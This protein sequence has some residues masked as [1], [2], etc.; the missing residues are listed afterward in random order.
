VPILYGAFNPADQF[1]PG[2]DVVWPAPGV[3]D[4]Q[5]GMPRVRV[6]VN[7]L[8][9][10]TSTNGQ[11]IVRTDKYPDMQG[12]L[13]FGDPVG[14]LVRRA[15]IVKTEGLTQLRNVYPGSEFIVSEDP[16]FRPLNIK[17]G[18]D[19][20]LY[21]VDM[22][23]GIIQDAN[24]TGRG[25]YLRTR[26]EQYS[27]DKAT[28]HG[29]VWRLRFDGIPAIPS[30]PPIAA[31]AAVPGIELDR[32]VPRML[33]ET[34]AQLVSHL[35]SS[36]GWW[37]DTAQRLL[38]LKQDKS[39]V[40][41][42]QQMVR[43]PGSGNASGNPGSLVARFHAMW[44][45]EGLGALDA[46]L[47]RDA[48]K[49]PSPRMRVQAI[50]A[51]ETLYKA[52]NRTF[53]ADYRAMAKDSDADVAIQALMTLNLFK[54]PDIADVVKTAQ[55]AN[56]GRGVK[57]LGDL[58]V[59]PA[60]AGRGGGRGGPVLTAEQ[61]QLMEKG[62]AIYGELCFSCHGD[63]G[64]GR[65]LAGVVGAMMAP[66]LAGSPRVN[67]HR[68]YVV[69]T[70]LKGLTGPLGEATYSEVMVPMGTNTDE[71]IA[72]ISSY[73]RGSFGNPGG[74]VS[75]PDVARVRAATASRKT[76]WTESTLEATLPHQLDV[77]PEWKVTASH[78]SSAA[79]AALSMRTWT[80]GAPQ[81]P[82]MW[83]QV[84][85][86]QP[87]ML[88]EIQFDAPPAGRGGGAGRGGAAGAPAAPVIPYP[89]G[90]RVE[91]SLD[92]SKWGKPVAEGKG[93]GT[94]T[95]VAF[96]PVRAKFVRITQTD[97]VDN[98]PNWT[99]TNVRLFEAGSAK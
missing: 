58:L 47:V 37:R 65:P 49:D 12:D 20:A 10:F 53:D 73:V 3:G 63:D 66:A 22:Y 21:I 98:G 36:N 16:L 88:T 17:L 55:G 2:F 33:D 82:G 89:R 11:E 29:R 75:A 34:A 96:A 6:P 48:M 72:A 62:A 83:F 78:N 23:N 24:W 92:G 38:V 86:P 50:R 5:G 28:N 54:A 97:T 46:A 67:G 95:I 32:T 79:S 18:P 8:N 56:S 25:T 30:A 77:Q 31:R 80:S 19:G 44:T 70:L 14:R 1:E 15:K 9:H 87:V 57:E 69:K 71:W 42:L 64:R 94:R 81:A 45:L 99:M 60:A 51:S 27:L 84:E 74:F 59:R 91:A 40:P 39:V 4:M 90:Y 76:P 68:D 43:N 93:A 7:N 61:Q 52:G 35:T 26:I 13:L 85:L 41:A